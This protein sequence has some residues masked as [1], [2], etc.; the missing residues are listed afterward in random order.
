MLHPVILCGG[1]GTRLWPLSRKDHPKQFLALFSEKTLLQETL[2]RCRDLEGA[3]AP[4]L[5]SNVEHR[6]LVA[7][8][9]REAHIEP[10]TILLEPCGRNTAPAV[11]AAA[12]KLMESDSE[13]V[14]FVCPSDHVIRH[15]DVLQRAV[16]TGQALAE[17]GYLV[18]FG[19]TPES[20]HTGYGYIQMGE[21]LDGQDHAHQINQFVEK[22]QADVAQEYLDSGDYVWNSGMF[23]FKASVF[24]EE[25]KTYNP[26]IYAATQKAVSSGSQETDFF[27]LDETAFSQSPSDSIDYAVMEYTREGA[28]VD[29]D[30]GWNDVGSWTAL[31]ELKEK[32]ENGNVVIGHGFLKDVKNAYVHAQHGV[33]AMVGVEDIIVVDTGDTLLVTSRQ[34]EQKVKE[35]VTTIN[36]EDASLQE[37]LVAK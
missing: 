14:M 1:S 11:A 23:M 6:F 31:W 21:K 29:A 18:T 12:F 27:R 13:A 15:E 26:E 32:D 5:V 34:D 7:E 24:L 33:V 9:T 25:L 35:L 10:E 2:L 30:L 37:G 17:H 3:Q 28:V 16:K 19:I 36:L 22:P 20:P 4:L 8:Q